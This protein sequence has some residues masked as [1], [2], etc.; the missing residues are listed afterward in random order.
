MNHS[1]E[2]GTLKASDGQ[3]SLVLGSHLGAGLS[4]ACETWVLNFLKIDIK[5][6]DF[7]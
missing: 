1:S 6:V 7:D 4:N 2:E 5:T 3:L